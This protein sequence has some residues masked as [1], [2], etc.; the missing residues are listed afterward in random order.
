V[1]HEA[2]SSIDAKRLNAADV[3]GWGMGRLRLLFAQLRSGGS[4]HQILSHQ[5][6]ESQ[7]DAESRLTMCSCRCSG[8][9]AGS[10]AQFK[11]QL[12]G[13]DDTRRRVS[14]GTSSTTLEGLK[15]LCESCVITKG[16]YKV[17]F[18]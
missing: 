5:T 3:I 1:F 12:P 17:V 11:S 13:H 2:N 10:V 18:L 9:L 15:M 7:D 14:R 16:S 8:D 4:V 6:M